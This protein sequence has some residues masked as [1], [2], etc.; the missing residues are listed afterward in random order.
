MLPTWMHDHKIINFRTIFK[1]HEMKIR[2]YSRSDYEYVTSKTKQ[3][4]YYFFMFRSEVRHFRGES[5]DSICP[6]EIPSRSCGQERG[7]HASRRTH[8]KAQKWPK[9]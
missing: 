8:S 6:Q 9:N 2:P 7:S 1:Y 3:V 4:Y 5:S